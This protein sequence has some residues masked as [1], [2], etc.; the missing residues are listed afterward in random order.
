MSPEKIVFRMF[1]V[2]VSVIFICLLF[3]ML[4][5]YYGDKNATNSSYKNIYEANKV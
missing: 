4:G 1:L 2:A 5:Y 3:F